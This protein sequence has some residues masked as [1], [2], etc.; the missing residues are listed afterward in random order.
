MKLAG[1]AR[2]GIRDYFIIFGVIV[3]SITLLRQIFAP[4]TAFTLK[5]IYNYMLCA[6]AGDLPGLILY[7]PGVQSEKEMRVRIV[8]HF[9]VLEAVIL[10]LA[11][12]SGWVAGPA[13]T[14]ILAV[15]V[16]VIYLFV[17]LLIWLDDRKVTQSINE[18]LKEM[19]NDTDITEK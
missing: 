15:Q 3:I 10:T 11:N 2:K 7:S 4:D 17:R 8:L 12:V 16:A 19:K 18:K 13:G 1:L 9:V 14:A 5:D 6:L